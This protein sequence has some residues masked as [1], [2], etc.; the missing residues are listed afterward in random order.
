MR[1]TGRTHIWDQPLFESVV[2]D[3]VVESRV[4]SINDIIFSESEIEVKNKEHKLKI[5]KSLTVTLCLHWE[6]D[7]YI[8]LSMKTVLTKYN[9]PQSYWSLSGE[10]KAFTW[11]IML[12]WQEGESRI[13]R[14]YRNAVAA[15]LLLVSLRKSWYSFPWSYFTRCD[16]NFQH[17]NILEETKGI[18]Q[19]LRLPMYTFAWHGLLKSVSSIIAQIYTGFVSLTNVNGYC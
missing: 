7:M 3:V 2:I 15:C 18:Y 6:K 8:K 17:Q 16:I 1:R 12:R 13:T 9:N 5:R 14:H 4:P 10:I 19:K 11:S